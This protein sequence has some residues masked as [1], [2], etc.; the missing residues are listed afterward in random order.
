MEPNI[1][2]KQ[3]RAKHQARTSILRLDGN[4][5][6]QIFLR[7]STAQKDQAHTSEQ[8]Y[9]GSTGEEALNTNLEPT[10]VYLDLDVNDLS[11]WTE[12]RFQ[13][14]LCWLGAGFPSDL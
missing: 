12:G 2:T 6:N 13:L 11:E 3:H 4:S 8:S 14:R 9:A 5:W 1:I 10:A 7:S